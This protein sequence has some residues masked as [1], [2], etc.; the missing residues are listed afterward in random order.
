MRSTFFCGEF[1]GLEYIY[2]SVST[3]RCVFVFTEIFLKRIKGKQRGKDVCGQGFRIAPA[4]FRMASNGYYQT[5]LKTTLNVC[6]QKCET[7]RMV[8]VDVPNQVLLPNTVSV[9]FYCTFMHARHQ[10][11]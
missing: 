3:A 6:F 4:C 10:P 1:K 7:Y 5:V 8:F 2:Y 9:V 11:F